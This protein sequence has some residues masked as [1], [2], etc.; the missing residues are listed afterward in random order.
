MS[1]EI[2]EDGRRDEGEEGEV[3]QKEERTI[4]ET[5]WRY[6]RHERR[7]GLTDKRR[8]LGKR[9]AKGEIDTLRERD[10][11]VDYE[12]PF[13]PYSAIVSST[14]AVYY[15]ELRESTALREYGASMHTISGVMGDDV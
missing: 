6:K 2:D 13:I 7:K 1:P 4:E 15:F 5:A 10:C 14:R 9:L 8:W 11:L 12:K 3:C